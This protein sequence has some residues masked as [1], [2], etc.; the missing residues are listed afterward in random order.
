MQ[1][2]ILDGTTP[3]GVLGDSYEKLE[4]V[5]RL[6]QPNK[7]TLD[8]NLRQLHATQIQKGRILWLAEDN[9]AF[10][11]EHIETNDEPGAAKDAMR[12]IGRSIDAIATEER[13]ANPAPGDSHDTQ[14]AVT[15]EAAIK[16]YVDANAG[17]SASAAREIP[18]FTVAASGG[19]GAV[20]SVAARYQLV[21]DILREIGYAAGM[22][23]ETSFDPDTGSF[24]FDVVSGVDR[25]ASVFFDT[26]FDTLERYSELDSLIDTKTHAVVAGQGEGVDREIVERFLG[27]EKTGLDRRETFIDARD[28]EPGATDILEQRGDS[29]LEALQAQARYEAT[30]HPYGSFRYLTAQGSAPAPATGTQVATLTPREGEILALVA[31]GRSNGEIGK[32]LFISTKTVSVHVSNILAKLDAASRTEAAAL[33][34]RRGLL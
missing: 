23:W 6:W 26:A 30:V 24:V 27:S 12:V 19:A 16:H 13:L 10:L 8:L 11:I 32:Q 34:R 22:G 31:E 17:P 4:W 29:T 21:G 15:A 18:D 25:T 3:V 20:V 33:A 2:F 1:V 5:R 7:V 14:S 9:V 28:V